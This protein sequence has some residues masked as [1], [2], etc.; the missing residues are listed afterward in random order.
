MVLTRGSPATLY[1]YT[2]QLYCEASVFW[3]VAFIRVIHGCSVVVLYT[4]NVAGVLTSLFVAFKDL[5]KLHL[6]F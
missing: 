3:L 5:T 1:Y 2:K 4:I 6:K